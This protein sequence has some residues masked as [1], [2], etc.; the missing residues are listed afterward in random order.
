MKKH[1]LVA[2]A[3]TTVPF[4]AEAQSAFDGTWKTD[5]NKVDFPNK[6]DVFLLQ[7]G[8]YDRLVANHQNRKPI[9]QCHRL[10]VQSER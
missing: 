4:L 2:L 1:L 8:M 10:D 5:M 7:N 3:A 9:G 6:P